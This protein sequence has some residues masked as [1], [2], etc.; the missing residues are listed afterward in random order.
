V[1]VNAFH[2]RDQIKEALKEEQGVVLQEEYKVLGTGGGLRK[3]L[4]CFDTDPVLVVNG[5][6]YHTID[7]QKV[8]RHHCASGAAVTMVLHDYPRF[9]TVAVDAPAR[10]VGFNETAVGMDKSDKIMAFTGIHVINP[11]ILQLI[12]TDSNYSIIDCYNLYLKQ[13][14]SITAYIATGH[15]W[16]DIGTPEDYLELHNGLIN[17]EIPLYDELISAVG[18]DGIV[19]SPSTQIGRNVKFL[20]WACIGDNV[21]IGDDTTLARVVIWDNVGIPAGSNLRDT[22]LTGS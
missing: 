20:D 16:S 8:Y 17:G 4:S 18:T 12:P 1:V 6:I 9:N 15:F 21:T 5:D 14:G 2:L 19:A 7:Y 22:I 10:V 3:A 13:Q 11:D